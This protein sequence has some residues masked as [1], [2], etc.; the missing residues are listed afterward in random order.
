MAGPKGLT[1]PP[2][3]AVVERAAR[4]RHARRSI[5][6]IAPL[7]WA[8]S[9]ALA[10]TVGWYAR[11][12]LSARA[13]GE[14]QEIAGAA[15]RAEPVV[16]AAP[17]QVAPPASKQLA[18]ATPRRAE[19]HQG[20][21]KSAADTRPAGPITPGAPLTTNQ[22]VA[23]TK[24]A[25][26]TEAQLR[27][28]AQPVAPTPGVAAPVAVTRGVS[29]QQ[30]ALDEVVVAGTAEPWVTVPP[31]EAQRRLG[32]PLATVPGLP[33]LGTAVFGA[34]TSTVARTVQVLG[35]GLTIELVQRRTEPAERE[36]AAAPA[37]AAQAGRGP[38]EEPGQVLTVQWEGF[39]ISGR[40][41]VPRDSLRKLLQKLT[42]AG[43]P[44]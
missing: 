20:A 13:G 41:L 42:A 21:R 22:A 30:R 25:A 9:V 18:Q 3:D 27:S 37:P 24:I 5:R 34:G 10:L 11:G 32:G 19:T 40:A 1:S 2:F 6:P 7:A 26:D 15:P 8:A 23:E 43:S 36:R 29:G 44:P 38:G 12:L 28:V 4:R 17:I 39:A 33:S 14:V 35:P 16:R 31:S